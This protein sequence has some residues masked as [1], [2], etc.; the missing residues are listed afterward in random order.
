MILSPFLSAKTLTTAA[1]LAVQTE[2]PSAQIVKGANTGAMFILVDSSN[3]MPPELSPYRLPVKGASVQQRDLK[4][5][6]IKLSN[7][8]AVMSR[9]PG[10]VLQD[11]LDAHSLSLVRNHTVDPVKLLAIDGEGTFQ[12]YLQDVCFMPE[13][14]LYLNWTW[15]PDV[16]CCDVNYQL[17]HTPPST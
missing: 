15:F 6:A 17:F 14:T 13:V 10:T 8:S 9:S 4:R 7:L 5:F 2:T 11:I 12:L 3:S 1:Q 16:N